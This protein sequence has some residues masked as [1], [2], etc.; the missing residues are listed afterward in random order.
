MAQ[1]FAALIYLNDPTSPAPR[2]IHYDL[3][4]A[5][6]LFTAHGTVKVTDFGLSKVVEAGHTQGLELTSQG[7]GTY[8]YLAPECFGGSV[9]NPPTIS[10]KVGCSKE[11]RLLPVA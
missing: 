8:W 11:W 7:A 9:S 3:K 1:I 4:P 6:V 5:N 10:S 2:V